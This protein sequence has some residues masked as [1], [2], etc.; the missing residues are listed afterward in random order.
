MSDLILSTKSPYYSFT[1]NKNFALQN[2]WEYSRSPVNQVQQNDSEDVANAGNAVCVAGMLRLAQWGISKLSDIFATALMAGKE[3]ASEKDVMK[4]AERMK[5]DNELSANIHYIDHNNKVALQS[6]FPNLQK[7]LDVVA[8]GRNA[9]YT[10]KGNFAVAPKSKPS[11]ILH[12]LGH[13]TNFEKSFVMRNLQKLRAFGALAPVVLTFMNRASGQSEDGKK[14]FWERNAGKIGFMAM[15][16]TI[17]EE[18]V[19]SIRGIKMAKKVMGAKANLSALK[20]NYF[21]AWMTYVLAGVGVGIASKI[22]MT[23]EQ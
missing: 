9:F 10:N 21:F 23:D 19:A 18:G 5:K 14:N 4:V 11:L 3:F 6:M 7:D 1:P 16:P 22:A 20:R 17:I 15:M 13:A 2:G 8:D 12:E